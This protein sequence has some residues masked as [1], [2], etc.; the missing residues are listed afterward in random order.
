MRA[1]PYICMAIGACFLIAFLAKCNKKRSV[2]GVF[3]KNAT[4]VFFLLTAAFG[5][6]ATGNYVYGTLILVG[7]AFG[8]LGDIYLDQKW[9]YPNDMK[10][11]L[12]AG[13]ISFGIGHFFYIAAM[14]QHLLKL[15]FVNPYHLF[16]PLAFGIVM[17]VGN[18]LLEKPMKQDFGEY[19]VIV[20]IYCFII[21]TMV[22]CAVYGTVITAVNDSHYFDTFI[23]YAIGAVSFLISDLILSPMYFAKGKNTP[24]NMVLNHTTYYVGQYLI[25]LTVLILPQA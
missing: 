8:M 4:S 13:F 22:G 15:Y 1:I 21:A 9:V 10:Q 12:Y 14:V 16:I 17:A 25:A 7:L 6:L 3:L 23:C 11:Y 24:L 2:T 5:I 20:T 19:R 18:L